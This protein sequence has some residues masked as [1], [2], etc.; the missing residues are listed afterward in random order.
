M[1]VT[2]TEFRENLFLILERALQGESVEVAHKGGLVR[3]VPEVKASKMARLVGRDTIRGTV[4]ELEKAQA[5]LD[6]A[7]RSSWEESGRWNHEHRSG[8]E[9]LEMTAFGRCGPTDLV[10]SWMV[11]L[12]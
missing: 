12:E 5:E 3:L 4:A 7:M 2:S 9:H 6:L 11:M 10:V 1:K 8:V